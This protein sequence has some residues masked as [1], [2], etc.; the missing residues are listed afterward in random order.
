M[1]LRDALLEWTDCDVAAHELALA[2][3]L[4]DESVE[5]ATDAKHVYWS[6]NPVG[7]A[8]HEALEAFA[9]AGFLEYRD[10]P[11]IQFRWRPNFRGSWEKD[12]S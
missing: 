10:E 5:F 11:D 2:L 9:K 12:Q 4:M 7:E 1:N 3:G 8:L 6:A